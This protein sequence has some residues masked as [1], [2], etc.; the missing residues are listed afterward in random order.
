MKRLI[1]TIVVI[2]ILAACSKHQTPPPVTPVIPDPAKAQ[3]TT[4]VQ[5][6]I[7]TSGVQFSTTQSNVQ[8]TWGKS[9]NTDH[10]QLDI[11]NLLSHTDT[12]LSTSATSLTVTL[13]MNTPYSWAVTSGSAKTSHTA[14]S[15]SWKFYNAGPGVISYPPYPAELTYPAAN[16]V[17]TVTTLTLRWT[18]AAVDPAT[19]AGYDLY[20]GKNSTPPLYK[21][22]LTAGNLPGVT[23]TSGNW[24]WK[25]ITHDLAGNASDSGVQPFNVQ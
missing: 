16:Q 18:G 12:T 11:T 15:D 3:L 4:P 7:C 21:S 5:N 13:L 24:Y 23:L 8:F 1:S 10:Y 17:L 9:A 2:I 20:L 19:I 25:V 6:N 14:T 22:G